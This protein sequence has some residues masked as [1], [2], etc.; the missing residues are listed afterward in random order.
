MRILVTGHKGYIGS[1]MVPSLLAEGFDLTGL[2]SDIY[3]GCSYGS[4]PLQIREIIKDIRDAEIRDFSGI[5][6][7]IHLAAVPNDTFGVLSPEL[8]YEINYAATIRLAEIAKRAGVGRFLLASSCASYGIQTDELLGE[9]AVLNPT[10]AYARSKLLA[11]Q[12]LNRRAGAGFHPVF[13][14][15]A[16]AYG[17]SPRHR[18]DLVLNNLVAWAQQT[19]ILFLKGDGNSWRPIVHVRDIAEAFT[20]VLKAPLE[21]SHN[22]VFNVGLQ[23]ENYRIRNIAEAVTLVVPAS[24]I[25]YGFGSSS[26]KRNYRLSF[27]KIKETLKDYHPKWNLFRG[28]E[29]L[30]EAYQRTGLS[31]EDI[32][33]PKYRRIDQIKALMKSGKLTQDIRWSANILRRKKIAKAGVKVK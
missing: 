24:R 27:M 14:R 29:E 6:A 11:E 13:M 7:V 18:L 9:E 5:D 22:R 30:Y 1:V 26:D 10:N 23:G 28:A 19:G 25:E 20:A 15:I 4:E 31:R 21:L 2:D 16:T 32:E 17:F 8:T 3:R 12:E 33:G